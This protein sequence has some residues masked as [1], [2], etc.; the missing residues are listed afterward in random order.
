MGLLTSAAKK[1]TKDAATYVAASA[2]IKALDA[3]IEVLDKADAAM[4]KKREKKAEKKKEQ[5]ITGNPDANRLI[6]SVNGGKKKEYIVQDR[7][8]A[9]KFTVKEKKKHC[10]Q[11]YDY[12]GNEIGLAKEKLLALRAPI[13]HEEN[14]VDFL[15]EVRGE[16]QGV[17][18]SKNAFSKQKFELES[19]Q[20]T[21]E[22]AFSGK[23]YKICEGDKL[24]AEASSK[25][26]QGNEYAIDIYEGADEL[27]VLMVGLVVDLVSAKG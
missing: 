21:I 19:K 10:L 26:R 7:N 14:P 18:K 25:M 16:K 15:L 20:W 8:A 23:K 11:F 1:I 3:S 12:A 17:L 13:F 27:L 9:I 5:I 4:A 6:V 2:A 24:I 22:S